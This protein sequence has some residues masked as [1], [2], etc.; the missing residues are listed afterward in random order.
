MQAEKFVI[1]G[2][3]NDTPTCSDLLNAFCFCFCLT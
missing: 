2:G 1:G 3:S